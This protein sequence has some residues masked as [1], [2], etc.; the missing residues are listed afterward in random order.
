MR[1]AIIAIRDR[2]DR[3]GII[4]SGLCVIHC[5]LGVVLV[6]VLGLGGEA[7]LSPAIHRVGLALA[8]TVGL[9]SLSFGMRRHGRVGPLV[10]GGLGLSL[11]AAAL[12]AGHGLPEAV[13]TVMGVSLVAFAHIRNLR[14]AC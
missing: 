11:M 13:L 1:S 3:A 9:V 6:G 12:A 7:L 8:L 5:L 4:L 10:I 14:A 2:L